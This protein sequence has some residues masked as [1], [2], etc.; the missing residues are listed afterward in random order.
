MSASSDRGYQK[1]WIS[2]HSVHGH[3]IGEDLE[4]VI[5]QR[6]FFFVPRYK[7]RFI[8]PLYVVYSLITWQCLSVWQRLSECRRLLVLTLCLQS[9]A[10]SFAEWDRSLSTSGLLMLHTAF[11]ACWQEF[12]SDPASLGLPLRSDLLLRFALA[13]WRDE[14]MR[15]DLLLR[16]QLRAQRQ[17]LDQ[18]MRKSEHLLQ[19]LLPQAIIDSLKAH[20]PVDCQHFDDVTDTWINIPARV[21]FVQVCDFST[22]C[23]LLPP[24]TTVQMLDK[25]FQELDRLSDL[26]KVHKVETVGDVYMAVAGCPQ[27]IANHADVAAHFAIA[28]QSSIV[29]QMW[30]HFLRGYNV[31]E[32][33]QSLTMSSHKVQDSVTIRVGQKSHRVQFSE[34]G[35]ALKELMATM[36]QHSQDFLAGFAQ[37]HQTKPLSHFSQR[38]SKWYDWL[39]MKLLMV[40]ESSKSPEMLQTLRA[41]KYE[42]KQSSLDT[43][44]YQYAMFYHHARSMAGASDVYLNEGELDDVMEEDEVMEALATYQQVRQHLKDTRLGRKFHKPP[45]LDPKGSGKLGRPKGARPGG[46]QTAEARRVHIEQLK[47]RTRCRACG[48]VG[49]WSLFDKPFQ[50]QL[51]LVRRLASNAQRTA[52]FTFGQA[53]AI[54]EN[55]GSQAPECAFVG[56]VTADHQALVDTCA[57]EGLIGKPALLRLCDALRAQGLRCL[58]LNKPAAARG[59]GGSAKTVG[60]VELPLGLAG[61]S[62]VLEATVVSEFLSSSVLDFPWERLSLTAVPVDMAMQ[63]LPSGHPAVSVLDFGSAGWQLPSACQSVRA[64]QQFRTTRAPGKPGIKFDHMCKNVPCTLF[65]HARV[66][67]PEAGEPTTASGSMQASGKPRKAGTTKLAVV[68]DKLFCLL[69]WGHYHTEVSQYMAAPLP[70]MPTAAGSTAEQ[71]AR[72]YK[73]YLVKG[74][75]AASPETCSH[76]PGRA[77]ATGMPT[78]FTAPSATRGADGNRAKA[79]GQAGQQA[80]RP[81]GRPEYLKVIADQ[82]EKLELAESQVDLLTGQTLDFTLPEKA[83]AS[84]EMAPS[85]TDDLPREATTVA[86][87]Y[88]RLKAIEQE[89]RFLSNHFPTSDTR[90]EWAAKAENYRT[91]ARQIVTDYQ[92]LMAQRSQIATLLLRGQ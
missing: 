80:Q 11:A 30:T 8:L 64:E 67:R 7:W 45:P 23:S 21:I 2:S 5:V 18:E 4:D 51:L 53:R 37:M 16:D 19:S 24:K 58:W 56:V 55:K 68:F 87:E 50:Y 70:Q 39:D 28:A 3:S 76:E 49:H 27:P 90:T 26:L 61:V 41:D 25:V 33:S 12:F 83:A 89:T 73:G 88:N 63:A 38:S 43:C 66:A 78:G 15:L 79:E 81:D 57:Q 85:M 77:G 6:T 44:C 32:Q 14:S 9:V 13:I 59:I 48:Q 86:R 1:A 42:F 52:F 65:G 74:C 60:V 34:G 35:N 75:P 82:K 47:L 22:I 92:N 69:R 20:E 62:G 40:P 54:C 84:L 72:F 31:M 91:A 71:K 36:P 29:R 17:K 10:V 46:R